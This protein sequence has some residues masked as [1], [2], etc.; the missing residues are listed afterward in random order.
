[1]SR[2]AS[3]VP[4]RRVL[5]RFITKDT[6]VRKLLLLSIISLVIPAASQAAPIYADGNTC[7][8]G[9]APGPGPSRQYS[10]EQGLRCVYDAASNNIQ[11]DQ[12]EADLY[13]NSALAAAA[14]W[15]SMAD[16]TDN[17]TGLGQDSLGLNA[18]PADDEDIFGFAFTSDGD[19]GTFTISGA[20]GLAWDQFA[21]GVKDGGSPMWAIFMLPAGTLVGDW[22]ITSHGGSLSHFALYGRNIPDPD[23]QIQEVPEPATL[24]LLGSGLT[25]AAR[26]R[27][28]AK[29]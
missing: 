11:G 4:E 9:P 24:L 6:T 8:T 2:H 15:H 13:L 1:M 16:L 25:F 3:C 28:R 7:P 22:D 10:V 29:R 18:N 17:W 27:N 23:T 20:L 5:S 19:N 12:G 26:R 14:G 21:I